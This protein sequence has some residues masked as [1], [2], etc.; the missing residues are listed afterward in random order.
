MYYTYDTADTA[1][2]K[3]WRHQR[4]TTTV[5]ES[6]GQPVPVGDQP[7][8]QESTTFIAEYITEEPSIDMVG[9][10]LTVEIIATVG[11]A[12]ETRTYE[13]TPRPSAE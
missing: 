13:I 6:D 12:T 11:G 2:Y 5:Y 10:K 7:D 3:L 4:I 9:G 1:N 8:P